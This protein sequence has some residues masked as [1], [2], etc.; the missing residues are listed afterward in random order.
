MTR[1]T[2]IAW[3][4][5]LVTGLLLAAALAGCPLGFAPALGVTA[6]QTL[7]YLLREGSP[8]AFPVQVR[9]G[10]LLWMLAGLWQPLG[11]FHWIQLAGTTTAVLVDYCPMARLLSLL[12]WNRRSPLNVRLVAWTFLR[13]PVRGSILDAA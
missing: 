6:V 13:P 4:Y 7:H 8:K 2:E 10:Y 11:F 1:V 3:W 9:T 5:W 12:P